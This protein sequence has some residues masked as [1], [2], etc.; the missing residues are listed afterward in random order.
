M[1]APATAEL[2]ADAGAS[3]ASE[4]LFR[5]PAYLEAE[6]VTHT[7]RVESPDRVTLLP[8]IVREIE[9]GGR[10]DAVSPYG[11]PGGRVEGTAP[12]PTRRRSSTAN[13]AR[14]RLRPRA[15]RR[16]RPRRRAER[17][18]VQ[19]HDP[20]RPRAVRGRLAEQVRA[21]ERAGWEVERV[22]GPE[23][24]DDALAGFTAAYEQTMRRTEAPERYFFGGAYY[25]AV[26]SFERSW[27]LLRAP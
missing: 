15:A 11:Y 4:D 24:S 7:L 16:S 9:P 17:S 14:Q 2:V 3:A 23:A 20:S 18:R 8:L 22:A 19:V 12:R 21:A 26:L 13:R 27:L 10:I 6:G 1:S 25:R 5:A